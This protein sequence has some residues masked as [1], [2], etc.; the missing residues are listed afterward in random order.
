MVVVKDGTNTAGIHVRVSETG[1]ITIVGIHP[2]T[3]TN[4][5]PISLQEAL[6]FKMSAEGSVSGDL[7]PYFVDLENDRMLFILVT[8]PISGSMVL[9]AN[10]GFIYQHISTEIVSDSFMIKVTDGNNETSNI[11]IELKL[12]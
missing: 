12:N 9:N 8:A 10:G 7:T 11:M 5:S 3:G 2:Y 1:A 4:R 6:I